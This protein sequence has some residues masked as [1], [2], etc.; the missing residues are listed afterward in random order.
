MLRCLLF[1]ITAGTLLCHAQTADK[2]QLAVLSGRTL[3]TAGQPLRRSTVTLRPI[4]AL[5]PGQV[6][7]NPADLPPQP[8]PYS[9]TSDADGNFTFDG[10]DAGRYTLGVEHTGYL[11]AQYSA[12]GRSNAS[13]P[14]VLTAGQRMTG[15]EIRLRP[16]STVGGRILDADGEPLANARVTLVRRTFAAYGQASLAGYAGA[17]TDDNGV[18]KVIGVTPGK[19]GLSVTPQVQFSPTG[20]RQAAGEVN[21]QEEATITTFYPG[22]TDKEEAQFFDVAEGADVTG[23]NLTMRKG[24]VFHIRGRVPPDTGSEAGGQLRAMLMS[25][26]NGLLSGPM[27]KTVILQRDGSFDIGG[28]PAGSYTLVL[29]PALGQM[30]SQAAIPVTVATQNVE[31]LIVRPVPPGDIPGTL[32]V[33]GDLPQRGP[34]QPAAPN[35]GI[36]GQ[37]IGGVT[38]G[39]LGGIIGAT[40]A[41]ITGATPGGAPGTMP[42]RPA[43]MVMLTPVDGTGGPLNA[44]IKTDGTFQLSQVRAGKYRV[45][46]NSATPGGYVKSIVHGGRDVLSE[47]LD[48]TNG[49]SG[50]LVVTVSTNGGSVEGTVNDASGQPAPEQIVLLIPDAPRTDLLKRSVSNAAGHFQLGAIAPGRYRVYALKELDMGQ[51]FDPDFLRAHQSGS[52]AVDLPEKGKVQVTLVAQ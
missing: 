16:Q 4:F 50:S 6:I 47:T 31:D 9:T 42:A 25:S 2:N 45:N 23:I 51:Q 19:Y 36:P 46:V 17:S 8:A 1:A 14:I 43:G 7:T 52:Q 12:N 38:G 30:Q 13:S 49:A 10:V 26:G 18:Y 37:T 32:R 20:T 29:T 24:P 35:R 40:P 3:S 21:R 41:G 34:A 15:L 48:L 22:V 5:P 27:M 11:R 44:P 39:V 28:V 33:E